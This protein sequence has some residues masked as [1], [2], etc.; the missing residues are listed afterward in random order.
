MPSTL[1]AIPA[2]EHLS[3]E[4]QRELIAAAQDVPVE[5]VEVDGEERVL[6]GKTP[7]SELAL[8]RLTTSFVAAIRKAAATARV[9][10]KDDAFAL[11]LAEFV[12]AVRR[13]DLTSTVPFSA[14]IGTILLRAVS[15]ASR[16]SDL[17]TV[18][19]NV[20][21]RYWRLMHKHDFDV[22]AAYA[23][24]RD[25]ANG[26]DPMTFLSVHRAMAT[27]E[28]IEPLT[29]GDGE[30]A[31]AA[32]LVADHRPDPEALAVE[33]DLVTWLFSLVG[34][35]EETVLRL[36]YGFRDEAT[37]KVLVNFGLHLGTVLSDVQVAEVT[38]IARS[39][40]SR[41]GAGSLAAMRGALQRLVDEEVSA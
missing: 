35:R 19:E 21:A 5:V 1:S 30:T 38:G 14:T 17:I 23:E 31:S 34:N 32:Y 29:P 40:V 12:A 22:Q 24:C 2:T 39:T 9:M 18:R 28:T 13:Y 27:V 36:R 10:D 20:A 37:E 4:D 3:V 8:E 11:C 41:L 25:T 6:Y 16:T 7:A 33:A 26:F 15:D